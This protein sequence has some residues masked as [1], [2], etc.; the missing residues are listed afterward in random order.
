MTKNVFSEALGSIEGH[1]D[2]VEVNWKAKKV[3]LRLVDLHLFDWYIEVSL[4]ICWEKFKSVDL[5]QKS[6]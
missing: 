5:N 3:R 2:E 6:D 1:C 4:R